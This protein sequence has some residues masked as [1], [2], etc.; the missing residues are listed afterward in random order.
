[1]AADY[2][3][4]KSM[5]AMNKAQV[6]MTPEIHIWR[7]NKKTQKSTK[8]QFDNQITKIIEDIIRLRRPSRGK[9]KIIAKCQQALFYMRLNDDGERILFDYKYDLSNDKKTVI[10]VKLFVL[11]VSNKK[12]IQDILEISAEH[13]VHASSLD[14]LYPLWAETPAEEIDLSEISSVK[15]LNSL[16]DKAKKQ[17]LE[18]VGDEQTDEWNEENYWRR[19]EH[20]T[21]FDF[22]LPNFKN[23]KEFSSEDN[24]PEILKLQ[25]EQDKILENNYPQLLLEGVAGTGKTTMLLYRFVG[26]VKAILDQKIITPNELRAKFL[27]VTHNIRLRNEVKRYLRYFFDESL[28]KEVEK[29]V[30]SVEEAMNEIIGIK[31]VLDKPIKLMKGQKIFAARKDAS[32]GERDISGPL[33]VLSVKKDENGFI[34]SFNCFPDRLLSVENEILLKINDK[35][36]INQDEQDDVLI[37]KSVAA[38][39]GLAKRNKLTRERFRKILSG[40]EIDTDMFWEEYRGILRGYNLHGNRRIVEK[41]VYV[42]EIGRRRGRLSVNVRDEFYDIADKFERDLERDE[43]LNPRN[44]GWD[45]LDLC[46]LALSMIED[47]SKKNSIDFLYIDEIQDLTIAEIEVFLRRLDPNGLKRLSMAGDLSQ[48]VQPS[49]FTWQALREQIF[50]ILK[51]RVTKEERL[52]QNFRSTPFL[53]QSANSVLEIIGE[54]EEETPRAL[55]RPFAGENFGERLLRFSGTEDELITLMNQEGLPN[56]GCVLLVRGENEKA[57][58]SSKLNAEGRIFVETIVKFKGLEKRNVLL[59]DIASG[60]ERILDLLHHRK[61]GPEALSSPANKTTAVIELKHVFVALTRAR[62]LCGV[63][64]PVNKND[65]N[66]QFFDCR[67]NNMDYFEVTNKEKL[68]LFSTVVGEDVMERFANEYVQ[69]RQFGMASGTY[70]NMIGKMHESHYYNGRFHIEEENYVEAIDA[71]IEAIDVGGEFVEQCE[72]LIGEYCQLSFMLIKDKGQ[73]DL[74]KSKVLAYAGN[75][76]DNSLKMRFQA[77]TE[78]SKGNFE[79]AAQVY[80]KAELQGEFNRVIQAIPDPL[81]KSQLYIL[82]GN[83]DRAEKLVRDYLSENEPKKALLLS[84]GKRSLTEIFGESEI[85]A[86]ENRFSKDFEWATMLIKKS[87]LKDFRHLVQDMKDDEI[88]TK[89]S[90]NKPHIL[91]QQLEI[92]FR[93]KRY[94]ELKEKLISINSSR[95]SIIK[96][97]YEHYRLKLLNL[98]GSLTELLHEVLEDDVDLDGLLNKSLP[99]LKNIIEKKPI[100]VYNTIRQ[101]EYPFRILLEDVTDTI[102]QHLI[103]ITILERYERAFLEKNQSMFDALRYDLLSFYIHKQSIPEQPIVK[104]CASLIASHIFDRN[105]PFASRNLQPYETFV[106]NVQY[107]NHWIKS[108]PKLKQ[109]DKL[110]VTYLT[111]KAMKKQPFV[112]NLVECDFNLLKKSIKTSDLRKLLIFAVGVS[113][114]VTDDWQFFRIINFFQGT[115]ISQLEIRRTYYFFNNIMDKTEKKEYQKHKQK[116]IPNSLEVNLTKLS[117]QCYRDLKWF[118]SELIIPNDNLLK[119]WD[120]VFTED[121][122]DVD[123]LLDVVDDFVLDNID[124]LS[125]LN[126]EETNLPAEEASNAESLEILLD[127][128]SGSV[129]VDTLQ[130]FKP[131]EFSDDFEEI[132]KNLDGNERGTKTAEYITNFLQSQTENMSSKEQS[133]QL[134]RAFESCTVKD[135]PDWLKFAVMNVIKDIGKI[136]EES[137]NTEYNILSPRQENDYIQFKASPQKKQNIIT[138]KQYYSSWQRII[139]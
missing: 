95:D 55:Q 18:T 97:S 91:A 116:H 126:D 61:R 75:Y 21:I 41:Q 81:K 92:Y 31:I 46:K 104:G 118:V 27:F 47:N 78:E 80:I 56:S 35:V 13:K 54:Y 70:R 133:D 6:Y 23:P 102:G 63:I 110:V 68:S 127:E 137:T 25:K 138:D 3:S 99:R 1:M 108:K 59:W 62:F 72:E 53:V 82:N 125:N 48:S 71:L 60:S 7:N 10:N 119:V 67:F 135:W 129:E 2:V 122:K 115:S 77:E 131:F 52:D 87:E 96:N 36:G 93:R 74:M 66:Q 117:K 86:L 123:L 124:E 130:V 106:A 30:L 11:A 101:M 134:C 38:N 113:N 88:L 105:H 90:T 9:V 50:K 19:I 128:E 136:F 73:F 5:G 28:T 49:A 94:D 57:R 132:I 83:L 24:I 120:S 76:I 17:F 22:R 89:P 15:N 121:S 84:L 65:L 33:E 111:G 98:E 109:I 20:A 8:E 39:G 4:Y 32:R 139:A 114:Q 69:A 45:D 26:N 29:C 79:N 12:N 16:R 103:C 44:G 64:T 85:T 37:I 34:T 107:L 58:L 14:N 43:Y 40:R 42:E 112:C 51:I 100:E